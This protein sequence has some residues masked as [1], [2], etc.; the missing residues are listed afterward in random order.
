MYSPLDL[1][2]VPASSSRLEVGEEF[3]LPIALHPWR[4]SSKTGFDIE[5]RARPISIGP[6]HSGGC[7]HLR[8]S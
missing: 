2:I 6:E 7:S 4:L 5:R 8:A 1:M 3:M